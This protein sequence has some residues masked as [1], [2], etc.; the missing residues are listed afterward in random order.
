MRKLRAA[1]S[2]DDKNRLFGSMEEDFRSKAR[3]LE[4]T[5]LPKAFPCT[6]YEEEECLSMSD[7]LWAE[8]VHDI[9]GVSSDPYG[10][11]VV[12]QSVEVGTVLLAVFGRYV[13]EVDDSG[14]GLRPTLMVPKAVEHY[15]QR[16]CRLPT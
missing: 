15:K 2:R 5:A 8:N 11:L 16:V 10:Q 13:A 1:R 12:S 3:D 7:E 14:S 4:A 6:N 9:F